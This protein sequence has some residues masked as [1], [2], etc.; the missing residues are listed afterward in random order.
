M[1][2][3]VSRFEIN[4]GAATT[5]GALFPLSRP[6]KDNKPSFKLMSPNGETVEQVWRDPS[7]NIFVRDELSKGVEKDQT[8]TLVDEDDILEAKDVDLPKDVMNVRVY[9]A[10][11]VDNLIAPSTEAVTYVFYPDNNDR[12]APANEGWA[13][14]L[15]AALK[16]PSKV[17]IAKVKLHGNVGL[18]RLIEWRGHLAVQRQLSPEQIQDHETEE[19][20]LPAAMLKKVRTQ[21]DS[22]VEEFDP[23]EFEDEVA[24]RLREVQAEAG[25]KK[26]KRKPK[27]VEVASFSLLDAIE[28]AS[29]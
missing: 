11:V 9:N 2:A 21:V 27:K 14:Y 16:D 6:R 24:K 29:Q 22:L 15:L 7:G 26:P 5:V 1:R 4:M 18:F 13:E 8:L 3:Y 12:N 25:S 28:A 19:L 10:T 17:F 20:Q 23:S